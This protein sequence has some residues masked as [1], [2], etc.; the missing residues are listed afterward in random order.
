[1]QE[2]SSDSPAAIAD[3]PPELR[4][5]VSNVL[6]AAATWSESHAEYAYAMAMLGR[7]VS[8]KSIGGRSAAEVCARFVNVSR[9]MLE[10]YVAL[11]AGLTPWEVRLLFGVRDGRGEIVTLARLLEVA[12]APHRLRE[13]LEQEIW[14][15]RP[16][17][18]VRVRDG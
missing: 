18:V 1:M 9:S 2:V 5:C 15:G 16:P 14:S 10:D 12:R 3:L 8:G 11:N 7:A 6:R 4:R 13:Q 17:P